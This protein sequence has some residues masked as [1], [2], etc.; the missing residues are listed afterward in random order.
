[1]FS[2]FLQKNEKLKKLFFYHHGPNFLRLVEIIQLLLVLGLV[3]IVIINWALRLVDLLMLSIGV[4]FILLGVVFV[5]P[6]FYGIRHNQEALF[7]KQVGL[8]VL[9]EFTII[10]ESTKSIYDAVAMVVK[11]NYP[12]YSALFRKAM[13]LSCYGYRLESLLLEMIQEL[14]FSEITSR[15]AQLFSNWT[16]SQAFI[17]Q[18][19]SDIKNSLQMEML[20]KKQH[21]G[22]YSAFYLA[23]AAIIPPVLSI[24][25]ILNKAFL[26]VIWVIFPFYVMV[27]ILGSPFSTVHALAVTWGITSSK[28]EKNVRISSILSNLKDS[29]SDR[30]SF[31][32]A[33]IKV[34]EKM[35]VK[36]DL[37]AQLRML[38]SLGYHFTHQRLSL[39]L[40]QAFGQKGFHFVKMYYRFVVHDEKKARSVLISLMRGAREIE[41]DIEAVLNSIK[42]EQ[43]R[44]VLTLIISLFVMGLLT[45]MI[46]LFKVISVFSGKEGVTT[47]RTIILQNKSSYSELLRYHGVLKE[48]VLMGLYSLLSCFF[49]VLYHPSIEKEEDYLNFAV[50]G[51]EKMIHLKVRMKRAFETLRI[52]LSLY[53]FFCLGFVVSGVLMGKIM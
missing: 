33:L 40:K 24:L 29:A 49:I 52:I 13:Q 30:L 2:Y 17:E 11:G 38:V 31:H 50:N 48:Q 26:L 8:M 42:A 7:I 43:R 6:V 34:L 45:N 5:P 22:T 9:Y 53:L 25:L 15:F 12:H 19:K 4:V 20:E 44:F 18:F 3:V 37:A 21:V 51:N 39:L 14:P 10:L 16:S 47:I 41:H 1:M 28:K 36:G 32:L 27:L 35:Q 46:A 23:L